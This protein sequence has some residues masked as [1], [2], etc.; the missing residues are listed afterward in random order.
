M[1]SD[2]E[3]EKDD[4][5]FVLVFK[6]SR[7]G[8][9]AADVLSYI[10][11]SYAYANQGHVNSFSRFG[12]KILSWMKLAS[13][14]GVFLFLRL[15]GTVSYYGNIFSRLSHFDNSPPSLTIME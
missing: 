4:I 13:N 1:L 6:L 15:D 3:N 5:T 2:I 9:N 8:R 7:F 10:F 12:L 11:L 14:G